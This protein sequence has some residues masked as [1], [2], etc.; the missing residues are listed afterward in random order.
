[1]KPSAKIKR[2]QVAVRLP[3]DMVEKIDKYLE[4]L[5]ADNPGFNFSRTDVIRLL[6]DKGMVKVDEEAMEA[7]GGA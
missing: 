7:K 5:Q 4:T 2:V 3:E 6:I 1:M